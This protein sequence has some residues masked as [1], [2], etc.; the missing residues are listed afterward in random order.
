ML[1]WPYPMPYGDRRR[2]WLLNA[3][4]VI[5]GEGDGGDEK[6]DPNRYTDPVA[7]DSETVS[8]ATEEAAGVGR[9]T[10]H[11]QKK[12]EGENGEL[13]ADMDAGFEKKMSY[14]GGYEL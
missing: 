10:H 12:R 7:K 6:E 5:R 1:N 14:S 2:R 8:A 13:R 11:R 4:A 9:I 3:G